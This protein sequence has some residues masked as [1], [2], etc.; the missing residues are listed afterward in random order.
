MG[1]GAITEDDLEALLASLTAA[2]RSASTRNHYLQL[3]KSMSKW[4]AKKGY[5]ARPWLSVDSD[6]KREKPNRRH[7]RL[8]PGEEAAL[9]TA[10]RP[11]CNG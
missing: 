3:F 2:G 7:R 10:P 9:C 4:G 6:L 1:I 5:L 11:G 8:M